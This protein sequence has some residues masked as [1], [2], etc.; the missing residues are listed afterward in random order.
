MEVP[1][2]DKN[3]H[4]RDSCTW[5]GS[6]WDKG[7]SEVQTRYLGRSE[8]HMQRSEIVFQG[9]PVPLMAHSQGRSKTSRISGIYG[10]GKKFLS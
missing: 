5:I 1:I 3:V 8:R 7:A 4:K 6:Q 10:L 9:T 2:Q